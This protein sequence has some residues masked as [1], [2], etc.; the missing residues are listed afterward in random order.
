[1]KILTVCLGN[2]CRSPSAEA[3]LREA[4]EQAGLGDRVEI[5]SAGTGSWHLGH[6]PD[7]RM[8]AAAEAVGLHLKG[9][10]R[11]VTPADF[12]EFDLILAMDRSNERDLQQMAR[13]QE[14]REKVKLFR[15]FEDGADA[16]DTPDPYYG[17]EEGFAHVVEIVRAGAQGVV[18]Q[19]QARLGH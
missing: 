10:A 13:T 16:V 5:D 6:P 4:F 9:A 11:R 17:G 18:K 15:T 12:T 7:P 1:M 14:E 2:I 8:A 19:V 3:A